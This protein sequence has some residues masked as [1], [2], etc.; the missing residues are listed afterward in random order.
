MNYAEKTKI[1]KFCSE[2]NGPGFTERVQVK[3]YKYLSKDIEAQVLKTPHLSEVY[4]VRY[5]LE[6]KLKI[7]EPGNLNN[8]NV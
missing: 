2:K 6:I 3:G 8:Y 4:L 1:T 7:R 5:L